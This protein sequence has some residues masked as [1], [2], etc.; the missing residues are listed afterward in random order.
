MTPEPAS[1]PVQTTAADAL[2]LQPLRSPQEQAALQQQINSLKS[3]VEGRIGRLS[4]LNL[5]IA[6]RK[7]LED[8]SAFLSQADEAMKQGDLQ[9]SMN[10]A[11]KADLLVAAIEKRY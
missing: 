6:D 3:G 7:A 10:F 5:S 4:H 11:Q 1:E 8:A 9:E 2:Q